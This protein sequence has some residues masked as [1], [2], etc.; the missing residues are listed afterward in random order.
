[1]LIDSHC[2]LDHYTPEELPDILARAT[3]AGIG[4]LLTI[5]TRFSRAH[6][7]IELAEKGTHDLS[8]WASIGTH[9]DHADEDGLNEEG[10]AA[11]FALTSHSSVVGIGETGLDYFHG[12]PDIRPLQKV[13]FV[14]HISVSRKTR[15]PLIIHTREADDDMA[16]LLTEETKKGNFPFLL[17]CFSSGPAL[18]KMALS[19]GGYISFSGIL[20]FGKAEQLREIAKTVPLERLLVETDAPYLAPTPM[21]GKRNEPSYVV[22]TAKVLADIHGLSAEELHKITTQNFYSLFTKAGSPP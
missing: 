2:H 7:Q 17:H 19:L 21:R 15:L 3:L 20:T 12:K 6:T 14:H 11:L 10:E 22:H 8:I 16:D 1:M 5:G 18:A 13:N 9:P 4:G